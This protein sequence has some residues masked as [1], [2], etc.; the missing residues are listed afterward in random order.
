VKYGEYL[1]ATHE[2]PETRQ[3]ILARVTIKDSASTDEVVQQF[4]RIVELPV[5]Q[6]GRVG[7]DG[8]AAR[9]GDSF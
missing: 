8:S 4:G 2:A 1:A 6:V 5:G 9:L 7:E 3:R